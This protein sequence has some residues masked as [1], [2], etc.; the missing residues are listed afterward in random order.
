[1]LHR[2]TGKI[3]SEPEGEKEVN[4]VGVVLSFLK[5]SIKLVKN[6]EKYM[7]LHKDKKISVTE[8]ISWTAMRGQ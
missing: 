8:H 3:K 4:V 2:I 5:G 7:F 1:M 6:L